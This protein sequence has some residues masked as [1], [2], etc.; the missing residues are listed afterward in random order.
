MRFEVISGS[1]TLNAESTCFMSPNYPYNYPNGA[2]CTIGITFAENGAGY[3]GV[4]SFSTEGDY[5]FL[6]VGANTYSGLNGPVGAGP[7]APG[8]LITF[9]S[10]DSQTRSGASPH[11]KSENASPDLPATSFA[12]HTQPRGCRLSHLR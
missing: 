2:S 8:S 1:C 7:L 11:H 9:S 6:R 5:D 12:A 4:R 3:L 10:D